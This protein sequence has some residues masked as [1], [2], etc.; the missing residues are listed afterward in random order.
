MG[1]TTFE[2]GPILSQAAETTKQA[3]MTS[4]LAIAH[5]KRMSTKALVIATESLS[6]FF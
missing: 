3:A 5:T 1:T 4:F 6:L 2:T